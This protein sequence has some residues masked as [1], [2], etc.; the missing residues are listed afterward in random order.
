MA[1]HTYSR[2][3]IHLVWSTRKRK[4]VLER[5]VRKRLSGY[6]YSYSEQKK[7]YM[8]INYVNTDHVHALVD[9]PVSY[10]IR[11]VAKLFKGSSSH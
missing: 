10:S 9:L 4:P 2:C 7:I 5:E 6:L 1:Q 11:E 3:V 8:L